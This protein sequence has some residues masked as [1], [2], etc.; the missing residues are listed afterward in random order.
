MYTRLESWLA[1]KVHGRKSPRKPPKKARRGAQRAPAYLAWVRSL[2]C[3]VCQCWGSEAAHTGT[4]GGMSMKASDWSAVPL[5]P[6]CHRLGPGAYHRIGR[7]QFEA[8][9]GLNLLEVCAELRERFNSTARS[10][11]A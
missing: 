7:A 3:L 4:D 10:N 5:C 6:N 1:W 11:A 8:R 9:N 2:P